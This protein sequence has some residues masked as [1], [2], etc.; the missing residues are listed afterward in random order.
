MQDG[1][2]FPT[3]S[4][5]FIICRLFDDGHSDRYEVRPHF[6]FDSHFSGND[7][8]RLFMCF[9]A[10]CMFSLEQCLFGLSTHFELFVFMT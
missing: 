10:I 6:S 5:A 4:P 9:L 3:P 2:H 1:S 7:V 8:E